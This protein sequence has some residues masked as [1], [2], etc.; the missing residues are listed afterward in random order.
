MRWI[1]TLAYLMLYSLSSYT[2][3]RRAVTQKQAN[4]ALAHL[5]CYRLFKSMQN[6]TIR[7]RRDKQKT[8]AVP[9]LHV[10]FD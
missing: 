9:L 5:H 1:I 10:T 2:D 7:P 3:S 6:A 4:T 8:H